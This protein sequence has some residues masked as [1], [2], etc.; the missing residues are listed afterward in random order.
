MGDPMKNILFFTLFAL[1]VL[2]QR[3]N[4]ADAKVIEVKVK[5]FEFLPKDIHLKK[6]E[7]VILRFESLDRKHGFKVPSLGIEA[8]IKPG[9]KTEVKLMP[10]KVGSYEF[11]CHL[12]C[13]SGHEGMTGTIH[14]E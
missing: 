14:V 11:H 3:S 10:D 12:F 1:A 13:G 8:V 2:P 4:A 6:G 9:E 5:K 7:P